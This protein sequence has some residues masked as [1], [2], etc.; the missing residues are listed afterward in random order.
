MQISSNGSFWFSVK[1]DIL[2]CIVFHHCA[3]LGVCSHCLDLDEQIAV[4]VQ[5]VLPPGMVPVRER[6]QNASLLDFWVFLS[7][8]FQKLVQ[9]KKQKIHK[10]L[11]VSRGG[12]RDHVITFRS[13]SLQSRFAQAIWC[14][15]TTCG[16]TQQGPPWFSDWS[17]VQVKLNV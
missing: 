10:S 13:S 15:P 4:C 6:L 3:M 8:N 14:V 11:L 16:S 17:K 5:C 1:L 2:F 7:G 9:K 12:S